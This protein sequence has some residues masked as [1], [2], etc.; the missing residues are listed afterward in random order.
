MRVTVDHHMGFSQNSWMWRATACTSVW[1]SQR[2]ELDSDHSAR[3]FVELKTRN[4]LAF[5]PWL[6]S[7]EGEW[8]W[9]K[10][11][12]SQIPTYEV[13]CFR[14]TSEFLLRSL[15]AEIPCSKEAHVERVWRNHEKIS[16]SI[17]QKRMEQ[18]GS[19]VTNFNLIKT[20]HEV[21]GF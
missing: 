21:Q 12:W 15:C 19:N 11:T 3:Y 8:K 18:D 13:I 16:D 1:A 5:C 20:K 6:R 7:F 2:D 17:Y 4:L 14:E 10:N 9:K